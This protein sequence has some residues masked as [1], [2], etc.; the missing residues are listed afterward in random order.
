[1]PTP[2]TLQDELPQ[3]FEAEA[4]KFFYNPEGEI[5]LELAE[6]HKR[7]KKDI[8]TLIKDAAARVGRLMA[9][10]KDPVNLS[11][12]VA[13]EL[14]NWQ[15]KQALEM[16][17]QEKGRS[18]AHYEFWMKR[19]GYTPRGVNTFIAELAPKLYEQWNLIENKKIFPG[20]KLRGR[21][22]LIFP[23]EEWTVTNVT[24]TC[25]IHLSNGSGKVYK[26]I[27]AKHLAFSSWEL[28]HEAEEN[29]NPYQQNKQKLEESINAQADANN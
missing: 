20:N 9:F 22:E 17:R 21:F 28:A 18:Y 3:V 10:S 26:N 8:E 19:Q 4:R 16:E 15:K 27:S 24:P 23:I 12:Q 2:E 13:S 14:K 1:M 25:R 6:L 7:Y 11:Q 29:K 5:K